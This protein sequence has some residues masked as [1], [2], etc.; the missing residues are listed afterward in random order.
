VS[1]YLAI[2]FDRPYGG[3]EISREGGKLV[4]RI[5]FG[6]QSSA[7]FAMAEATLS[8]ERAAPEVIPGE[9][10]QDVPAIT[11]GQERAG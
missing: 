11:A 7:R 5:P 1:W 3:E 2:G 10:I 6:N 4:I 8:V 9:V